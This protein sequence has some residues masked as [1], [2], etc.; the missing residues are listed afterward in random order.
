MRKSKYGPMV[1][2]IEEDEQVRE[3]L[4][5]LLTERGYSAVGVGTAVRGLALL[6]QG[7]RPRVIV[8]DPFTPNGAQQFKIDLGA[9]AAVASTPVIVGPGGLRKDPEMRATLPREHHLHGPLDVQALM[10]LV[11]GY[12]RPWG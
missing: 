1:L 9:N 8:L 6:A 3:S 12:C 5:D 2:I 7:F 10:R 11:H 4:G